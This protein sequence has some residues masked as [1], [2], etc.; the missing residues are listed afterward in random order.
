VA[1]VKLRLAAQPLP[2]LSAAS[3]AL[4]AAVAGAKDGSPKPSA[5]ASPGERLHTQPFAPPSLL[6]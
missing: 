3:R 5:S 2:L 1:D 4:A 6:L